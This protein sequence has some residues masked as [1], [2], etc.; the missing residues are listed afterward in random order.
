MLSVS[1][2]S[3]HVL[4]FLVPHFVDDSESSSPCLQPV[5]LEARH[6][7]RRIGSCSDAGS[8][9]IGP[10]CPRWLLVVKHGDAQ[11]FPVSM[12]LRLVCECAQQL[13]ITQNFSVCER[14]ERLQ[15]RHAR[16]S[17][18]ARAFAI[19]ASHLWSG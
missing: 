6:P 19:P 5:F 15:L 17:S 7:A 18:R 16:C 4:L 14:S 11:D 13:V 3:H 10:S 8:S 9:S 12:L 2:T 1:E